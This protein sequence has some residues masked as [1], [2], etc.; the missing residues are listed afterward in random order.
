MKENKLKRIVLPIAEASYGR[1]TSSIGSVP[2]DQNERGGKGSQQRSASSAASAPCWYV[3]HQDRFVKCGR[4]TKEDAG[5]WPA[6][7]SNRPT[8]CW[9]IL[10]QND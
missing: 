6:F 7:T 5:Y 9:L 10:E 3:I 4:E 2:D 8:S 1:E